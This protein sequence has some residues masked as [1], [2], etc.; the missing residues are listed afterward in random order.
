MKTIV[1]ISPNYNSTSLSLF[2]RRSQKQEPN[3]QQ[4]GDQ[5]T[6]NIAAFFYNELR[7]TSEVYQ[8]Q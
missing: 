6:K 5:V 7:S 8:I 4:V 1:T 3:F 2:F